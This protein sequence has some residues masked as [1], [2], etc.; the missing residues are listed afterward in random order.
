MA[1]APL[2][3]LDARQPDPV[4]IDL[5]AALLREGKLVAFPTETVY[6]LGANALDPEAVA[7]IYHAKG[8]PAWNP[9]IAHVPDVAAAQA[10][11]RRWPDSAQ[12][13]ADAFWPG[14]LTLVLPKAAHVPDI[15]TA[16]LDA[17]AVRVPAHKVALA[18]LRAAGVP[19]AAPSANRFTQLSPTTA[20][21][22]QS[23]LGDR[24]D[25]IL[26]GGPCEVGIESTVVDCSGD[27]VVIL[28][29]GMIT[30][31]DLERALAGSGVAVTVARRTVSHD[32]GESATPQRAPGGAD[33]HYAPHA[34]VW[35][36]DPEQESEIA[37]AL[38]TRASGTHVRALL[39][40]TELPLRA[41]AIVR[42]PDEPDAYARA[43]Y[44]KLHD[45][46]ADRISLIVIERP[47]DEPQWSGVRDRLARAS[48]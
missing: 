1:G 39:R 14:P 33:R 34:D 5:A 31:P 12:R 25:L 16:G 7:A 6:G 44:A 45:A 23:S 15:A 24:V 2:L 26:D 43:L 8:R 35:L 19:I 4:V 41:T 46:D 10:L 48:R 17:V 29:P 28:R 21:H 30:V 13:L 20:Q 32:Q 22:V 36:F 18:L 38:A 42:M 27:D 11:T 47:P 37:T 40:T 3:T 9:V